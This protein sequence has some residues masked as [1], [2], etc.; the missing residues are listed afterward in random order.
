M[1]IFGGIVFGAPLTLN[2]KIIVDQVESQIIAKTSVDLRGIGNIFLSTSIDAYSQFTE[3][4]IAIN[5]LGEHHEFLTVETK[6]EI[7]S[8][9]RYS[10]S[11]NTQTKNRVTIKNYGQINEINAICVLFLLLDISKA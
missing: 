8:E 11:L 9:K 5:F 2:R 10:Q 6:P 7:K 4:S 3:N 1:I